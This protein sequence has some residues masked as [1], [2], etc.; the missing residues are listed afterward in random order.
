MWLTYLE[1]VFIFQ[2]VNISDE[3]FGLSVQWTLELWE[4]SPI[5]YNDYVAQ[6]F[7]TLVII[8]NVSWAANQHIRVI[9]EGSRDTEDWSYDA[10]KLALIIFHNIALFCHVF[11]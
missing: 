10:E 2:R 1:V 11:H 9:S 4:V 5:L 3:T 8:R 6:L 7:S